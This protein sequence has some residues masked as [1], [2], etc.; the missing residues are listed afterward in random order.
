MKA[1]IRRKYDPNDVRP[2]D[3]SACYNDDGTMDLELYNDYL[4]REEDE[5]QAR[6][7]TILAMLHL[8]KTSSRRRKRAQALRRQKPDPPLKRRS[9]IK[10]QKFLTDPSTGAVRTV[11]PRVSLWWILYIQDP[12]PDNS[13]WSK[14]F[15]KRFRLPYESFKQLLCMVD[16]EKETPDDCFYRW[17]EDGVSNRK[18]S[19]IELLVLGSLR[20]LGR[21]WTFDDLEESTFID[22]EVHRVF[23]HKF[24]EFGANKLYPK[25]VTMPST[26]EELR[27]CEAEYRSAGFPGCIGS[28][29]ATHIPLE[30]V[31]FG[32][33]QAH[34]GYKMSGTTRTYNL[35][36][37]H[38]RKILHSTTGHPGRWNDKTLVR[39]D[40][41]MRQIR[42]GQFN[43]TMS[44]VLSDEHGRDVTLKG[45]Y[46]IVDNGYLT[47]SSTVPPLKNSMNRGEI[48]FSQWLESLRKDVECTFGILKGRWRVLKTGIRMH[49]TEVADNIWLTCCA[50]HNMLLDVDG[51]SKGWKNGV[52]YQW[53]LDSGDFEESDL[54][55]SIR[56]LIDPTGVQGVCSYDATSIGCNYQG[57]PN[58]NDIDDDDDNQIVA[59]TEFTATDGI[60]VNQLSLSMFRSMLINHF[61]DCY[62]KNKVV[63]PTR[64]AKQPRRVPTAPISTKT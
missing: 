5:D 43:S 51:L 6:R 16:D 63:W 2:I 24:V 52:P 62:L 39:F 42:E 30:K 55:D 9:R 34:L 49:N 3:E 58:S 37:N 31:S 54:P 59:N 21:G 28:T 38:R 57:P 45:A 46:V 36:V 4:E 1:I 27:D 8:H 12:Q 25:Y 11:T 29:D 17:R 47:W 22:K 15:R 10:Q 53:E 32:L 35:T 50:L 48:R 18:V 13:Q 20:Y 23:F 56:R 26:I 40:G 44:F 61:N 14:T 60:A 19:P 7:T 41:F 33:R 64:L